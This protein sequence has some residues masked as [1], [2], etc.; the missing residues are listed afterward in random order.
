MLSTIMFDSRNEWKMILLPMIIIITIESIWKI[1][2]KGKKKTN[3]DILWVSNETDFM[4]ILLKRVDILVELKF[5][6]KIV[7]VLMLDRYL[8]T[9]RG[10]PSKPT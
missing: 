4:V 9:S 10:M 7:T 1:I 2:H 6:F 8:V 3:V 5:E